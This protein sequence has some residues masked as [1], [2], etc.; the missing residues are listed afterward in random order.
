[1]TCSSAASGDDARLTTDELFV[2]LT[3][4]ARRVVLFHLHQQAAETFDGLVDVVREYTDT[5]A[6]VGTDDSYHVGMTLA[7]HHLP[8]LE[9][10]DL[11]DYDRIHDTVN[12]KDTPA[13][14][15]EW[16][17]LA[18]HR[19]LYWVQLHEQAGKDEDD[20]EDE[21]KGNGPYDVGDAW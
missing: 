19:E 20:N 8:R 11:V 6:D 1:M 4:R 21:G 10:L 17:D 16:L 5:C 18:I 2:T 3:S 12:L 9:R 14:F 15:G 13:D 7:E